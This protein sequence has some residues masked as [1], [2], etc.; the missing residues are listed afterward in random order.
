MVI[1]EV[2][3]VMARVTGIVC[4]VLEAPGDVAITDPLNVPALRP[5]VLT[6][7]LTVPGVLPEP[8][9]VNQAAPVVLLVKLS[10]PPVL[11][12]DSV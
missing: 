7:T 4:G 3:W 8:V 2:G 1:V 10:T 11:P 12:T 9:A 6:E 5:V